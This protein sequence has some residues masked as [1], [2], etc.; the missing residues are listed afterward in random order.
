MSPEPQH[1]HSNSITGFVFRVWPEA[2]GMRQ[3]EGEKEFEPR[4]QRRQFRAQ[5]SH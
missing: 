2:A 4:G 5:F 1:P 3:K